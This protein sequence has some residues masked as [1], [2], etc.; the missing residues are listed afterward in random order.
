[1]PQPSGGNGFVIP[2]LE[3]DSILLMG[4]ERNPPEFQA[5]S[6]ERLEKLT[7]LSIRSNL[8]QKHFCSLQIK[9][10]FTLG[11]LLSCLE[12]RNPRL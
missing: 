3:V 5:L 9:T 8:F 12:R 6:R 7:Y 10:H 2:A 11:D 1:M 4:R